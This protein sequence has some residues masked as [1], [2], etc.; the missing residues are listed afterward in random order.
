M[1]EKG[2]RLKKC[3]WNDL[4]I[5][6]ILL[7]L[8]M[9][10]AI[11]RP[12]FLT[13]NNILNIMRQ[14]SIVAI[15][16][17]GMSYVL[18]SA[19][20]DLSV[21]SL[22][23][24]AGITATM[25]LKSG[26]GIGISIVFAIFISVCCG[27]LNGAIHTFARIPSFIVTMGML[28]IARG[29]VLVMTNSYPVTGL[30]DSFKTLG[31]GYIGFVPI[32]VIV[33]IICYAIGYFVLK[34]TKFGRSIYAIGGN[35]EAARLSGIPVSRNK[36]LIHT[37]SGLTAGIAGVVLAS[38]LFSGQPGAA[39]GLELDAIAACVIGGT[40]TSG[41]KGRLWGTLLGALIMG[42]ITNGMNLMNISTNWQL[43]MQGVII[44]VAVGLDRVKS[45]D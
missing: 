3:N 42:I 15:L 32:P 28:N 45:S 22:A 40:S 31:R 6:F 2:T 33:M 21:G 39:N 29:I 24:L 7:L 26:M 14:V 38:R 34:Y 27:F 36:V 8:I 17:I 11:I 35:L 30:P 25:S 23:A 5:L 20:I 4:A 18:I 12:V 9:I 43:I 16:G 44:I 19:E 13:P 10:L 1:K 41:G 37:I